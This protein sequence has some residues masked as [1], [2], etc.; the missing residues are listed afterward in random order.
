MPMGLNADMP[1]TTGSLGDQVDEIKLRS[2]LDALRDALHKRPLLPVRVFTNASPRVL[3]SLRGILGALERAEGLPAGRTFRNGAH[4]E[5]LS[6]LLRSLA[7]TLRRWV[8]SKLGQET[9]RILRTYLERDVPD[10][11]GLLGRADDENAHSQILR[12]LL[13]PRE[14][15]T[16][17][18]HALVGLVG[19]LESSDEWRRAIRAAVASECISVKREYVIGREWDEFGLDRIDIVVSGPGFMLAIEHKLWSL[20]HDRQTEAYWEWLKSLKVLRA[21]LFLS[22]VGRQ[23]VSPSFKAISY[24]DLLRCLLEA[25]AGS[26]LTPHEEIVLA[27]YL[28]TLSKSV[29]PAEMRAVMAGGGNT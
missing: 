23:P 4:S 29:L 6:E 18:P 26:R 16:I 28:K 5:Q 8:V 24:F 22:P 27:T 17:A 14:A 21:G 10:F 25:A 15:P 3:E 12:W 2:C 1:L 20:E 7:P 13:D 9:I 19:H 11:L